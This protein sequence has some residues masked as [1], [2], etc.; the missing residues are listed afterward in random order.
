VVELLGLGAVVAAGLWRAG[1][2]AGLRNR[3]AAV[4]DAGGG[5]LRLAVLMQLQ[6]MCLLPLLFLP[7]LFLLLL[8]LL[9]M[10]FL[11]M[12]MVMMLMVVVM[13]VMMHARRGGRRRRGR[14]GG[15]H[16][17]RGRATRAAVVVLV[18]EKEVILHQGADEVEALIL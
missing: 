11:L 14:H 18:T 13:V 12:L 16:G 7:L 6:K 9:S 17:G 8:L 15:R 2:A 4:A 5:H 1:V 3:R 10:L